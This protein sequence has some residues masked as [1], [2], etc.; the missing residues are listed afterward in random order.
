[1]LNEICKCK[2][3]ET[4][5][6]ILW[7]DYAKVICIFLMV[8]GHSGLDS[9]NPI[10][11]G[12]FYYFHIPCFFVISGLLNNVKASKRKIFL[13]LAIPLFVFNIL[14]YPWYVYELIN[15]GE[16]L[17]INALLVQPLLGLWIHDFET[18]RPLC[19]PFWFVTVLLLDKLMLKVLLFRTE[20]NCMVLLSLLLGSIIVTWSSPVVLTNKWLFMVNKAIVSLPFFVLGMLLRK[21][22]PCVCDYR[23]NGK[24]ALSKAVSGGVIIVII[25]MMLY[26][27]NGSVDMYQ[28]RFGNILIY[29][30]GG[31]LGSILVYCVSSV[32]SVLN[33]RT[34]AIVE[35]SKGT[36]VV[37]G[38]HQVL[39][40]GL[41]KLI[42]FKVLFQNQGIL[43]S[44]LVLLMLYPIVLLFNHKYPVL[45]GKIK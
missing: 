42:G 23:L 24:R 31:I 35:M 22:M 2:M 37:L 25:I 19:G 7:V 32:F 44:I 8:V 16:Q 6:R 45:L 3:K 34:K 29:Y 17:N 27:I 20:K 10:F 11:R 38:L 12:V 33:K 39:L 4:A 15:H 41:S 36:L 14:N 1:M 13:S 30:T 21:Y 28:G 9:V 5:K 18:G 43:M 26:H 40:F